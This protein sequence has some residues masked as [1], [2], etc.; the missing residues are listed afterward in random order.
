[1]SAEHLHIRLDVTE[2]EVL[3]TQTEE[4]KE[5]VLSKKGCPFQSETDTPLIFRRENFIMM[6]PYHE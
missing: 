1:M 4:N 3:K 2:L 5:I 6:D